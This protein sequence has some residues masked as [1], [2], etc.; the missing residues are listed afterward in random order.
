MAQLVERETQATAHTAHYMADYERTGPEAFLPAWLREARHEAITHFDRL[1]FPT[2]HLEEWKFTS[3]APIAGRAFALAEEGASRVSADDVARLRLGGPTAAVIV[4]VNGRYAPQLSSTGALPGGVR[5]T[6]LASA[7]V[8]H[9][10]AL[11][12]HLARL[13]PTDQH[14]FTAL[15]RGHR[16]AGSRALHLDHA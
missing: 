11:E 15:P 9:P 16:E 10:D 13:A 6:G 3:V 2:T 12:H 7:L 8:A 5:I 1:G 4:C 14:A